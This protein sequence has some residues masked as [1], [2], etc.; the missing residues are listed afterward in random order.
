VGI[1]D[2][3]RRL[4][5]RADGMA[6]RFG[7]AQS[8]QGGS[9]RAGRRAPVVAAALVAVII[10]VARIAGGDPVL[11]VVIG[12]FL[13]VAVVTLTLG[14]AGTSEQAAKA[15]AKRQLRIAS[16]ALLGLALYLAVIGAW[17]VVGLLVFLVIFFNGG[18]W[19]AERYQRSQER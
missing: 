9:A 4:D 11:P 3:L 14:R 15:R 12:M 5:Q 10:G 7:L 13:L 8:D 16:A 19:A 18:L 17:E 2:S 6:H 1:G